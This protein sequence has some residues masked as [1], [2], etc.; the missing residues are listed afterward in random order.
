MIAPRVGYQ[1]MRLKQAHSSGGAIDKSRLC[2]LLPCI[3]R[4]VYKTRT[5]MQFIAPRVIVFNI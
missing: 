3:V 2:S 4:C 1:A 5:T